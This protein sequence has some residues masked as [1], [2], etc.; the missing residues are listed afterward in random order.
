MIGVYQTLTVPYSTPENIEDT[1][2]YDITDGIK[3]YATTGIDYEI[4]YV[5]SFNSQ[6]GLMRNPNYQ[7]DLDVETA[8]H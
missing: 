2:I 4:S 6:K 8:M 7:Y 1:V 5:G 3:L